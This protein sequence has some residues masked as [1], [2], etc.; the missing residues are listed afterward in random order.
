M[1]PFQLPHVVALLAGGLF[2]AKAHSVI[3]VNGA[4]ADGSSGNKLSL[5][6]SAAAI[7]PIV[8]AQANREGW[9]PFQK[10]SLAQE[11]RP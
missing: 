9:S 1:D 3:I 7:R 5:G 8:I 11:Y 6:L 2:M 10:I 4:W